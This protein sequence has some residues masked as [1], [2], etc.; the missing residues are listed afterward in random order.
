MMNPTE[1]LKDLRRFDLSH[2]LKFSKFDFSESV[3]SD[4]LSEERSVTIV[5]VISPTIFTNALVSLTDWDKKR[6]CE[7]IAAAFPH[8]E[9][10]VDNLAFIPEDDIEISQQDCLYPE[11][12]AHRNQMISVATGGEK[13]Q[14][15]NDY[16]RA[17]HSRISRNLSSL[18]I[19]HQN[20]HEDLWS[21][22]NKWKESFPTYKERREYVNGLYFSAIE[23]LT[24]EIIP[25]VVPREPTG[26]ERVDRTLSKA[27]GQIENACDEEDF[28]AIGLLCRE[29][30]ISLGQAVYDPGIHQT[31]DGVEASSTDAG[32]MIEAFLSAEIQGSSNENL[33]KYAKAALKLAV[34]LQHK[35]TAEFR[36]AALCLEATASVVHI[37]TILS[38]RRDRAERVDE[39]N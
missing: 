21:W 3:V 29:I 22:Y 25:S 9:V 17:R 8:K 12:I 16:Y 28:Q 30:L 2:L 36:I 14:D 10:L 39:E 20:P 37:V 1:F 4:F 33:R 15:V 38:N 32:R 23:R 31:I 18:G 24:E 19:E 5:Q 7:A 13:I 27:H 11:V 6:I 35:R 26:W 34:E